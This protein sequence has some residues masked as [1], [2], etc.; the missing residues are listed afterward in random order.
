MRSIESCKTTGC[1][2]NDHFRGVT[3]MVRLGSGAERAIEDFIRNI[4]FENA[5]IPL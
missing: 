3:K 5:S 2:P 4:G 1:D